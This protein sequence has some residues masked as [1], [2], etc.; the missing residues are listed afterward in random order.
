[1]EFAE[2]ERSHLIERT[3]DFDLVSPRLER[4]KE[5]RARESIV[6]QITF[7]AGGSRRQD[8]K[9]ETSCVPRVVAVA[10]ITITHIH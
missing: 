8:R 9:K 5:A 3:A 2:V 10:E 4:E 7:N 6:R 1:M